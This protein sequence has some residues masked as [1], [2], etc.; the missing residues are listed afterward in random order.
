MA[1]GAAVPRLPD[2]RCLFLGLLFRVQSCLFLGLLHRRR[3][4]VLGML[5]ALALRAVGLPCFCLHLLSVRLA[6]G[7]LA[8]LPALVGLAL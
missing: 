5:V 6:K 4:L 7:Q 1:V 8:A 3:L 2:L